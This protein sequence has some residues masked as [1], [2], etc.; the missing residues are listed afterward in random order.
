M[1]QSSG[2]EDAVTDPPAQRRGYGAIWAVLAIVVVVIIGVIALGKL[3]DV[4]MAYDEATIER[5]VRET[6]M[7]EVAR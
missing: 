2:D 5:M 3:G 6:L 4:Y 7:I 1:P